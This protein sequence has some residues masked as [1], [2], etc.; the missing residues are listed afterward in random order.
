[1]S[2]PERKTKKIGA[3][4]LRMNNVIQARLEHIAEEQ[5][6]TRSALVHR[7]CED[8]LALHDMGIKVS[9]PE[10]VRKRIA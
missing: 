5:G 2:A 4:S 9:I 8:Y 10:K 3:I 7:I 6:M 1:M